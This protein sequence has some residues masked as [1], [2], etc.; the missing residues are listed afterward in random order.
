M[1]HISLSPMRRDDRLEMS[2]FADVFYFNGVGYDF[3]ALP[4]DASIPRAEIECEWL[5]GDVAR[6]NGDLY[7]TVIVPHGADA[8][9]ETRFPVPIVMVRD[10]DVPLPPYESETEVLMPPASE[11][12]ADEA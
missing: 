11:L 8:P 2:V 6:V 5:D 3:S 1:Y 4:D 10:G 7:L 12:D 9:L